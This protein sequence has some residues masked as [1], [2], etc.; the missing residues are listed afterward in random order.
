MKVFTCTK[1]EGHRFWPAGTSAVIVARDRR[2]ARRLMNIKAHEQGLPIH[3]GIPLELDDFE[4]VDLTK[5]QAIILQD[6][7]Y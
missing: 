1:F 6:G 5:E 7:D 2:H 3:Q 4:E